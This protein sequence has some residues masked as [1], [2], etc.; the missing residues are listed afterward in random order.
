MRKVVACICACL[1]AVSASGCELRSK[2]KVETATNTIGI[3]NEYEKP[4]FIDTNSIF[5]WSDVED[6][7][8]E[9]D[10]KINEEYD[11]IQEYNELDKQRLAKEIGQN[12]HEY[13]EEGGTIY[14][15]EY[16]LIVYDDAVR[17]TIA[18]ENE[19]DVFWQIGMLA[20]DAILSYYG[21]YSEQ[22]DTQTLVEDCEFLIED[23]G[24]S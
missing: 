16:A 6:K 12:L 9:I 21:G 24:I 19:E 5:S 3:A 1:I 18:C 10:S 11:Q 8:K 20:R 22:I 2:K 4:N 7:F 23:S 14:N 13:F 17:L 15:L